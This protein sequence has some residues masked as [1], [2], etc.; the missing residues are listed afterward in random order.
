[1]PE[2]F[3]AR[4]RQRREQQHVTLAT[5][6]AQTKIKTTLLEALE[7][8]DVS[9]WP[10]GIFRR[11]YIRA[12]A[13]AIGLEPDAIL[14]EFLDH[15]PDP[16]AL[17]DAVA[18]INPARDGAK[19]HTGPPTRLSYL[20]GT[21]IGSLEGVRSIVQRPPHHASPE[22]AAT[23]YPPAKP[24]RPPHDLSA[25][26]ALCTALAGA[27]RASDTTPLLEEAAKILGAVG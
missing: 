9:N 1:M 5:I 15:Y 13:T 4:L 3:G 24:A 18:A 20:V 12:Y 17:V 11:A 21:V 23:Q 16:A 10:A 8:D 2:S 14:R 7:R 6:V 25:V 27:E 19:G 22:S 26:A